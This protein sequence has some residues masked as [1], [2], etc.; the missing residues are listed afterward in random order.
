MLN[1]MHAHFII[2]DGGSANDA[3][4]IGIEGLHP[5]ASRQIRTHERHAVIVRRGFKDRF[6][7]VSRV[8]ADALEIGFLGDRKL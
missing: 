4:D 8:Q 5:R 6:A 1:R 3:Q 2:A 7:H